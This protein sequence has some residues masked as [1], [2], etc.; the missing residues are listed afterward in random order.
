[1]HFGAGAQTETQDNRVCGLPSFI[2]TV[3]VG[4]G[5]SPDPALS[6]SWASHPWV[7][8]D[9]ELDLRPHPAPKEIFDLLSK[10]YARGGGLSIEEL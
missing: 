3:T 1:M 7:T 9:R 5:V 6:R 8:T 4:S 2:R 10:V